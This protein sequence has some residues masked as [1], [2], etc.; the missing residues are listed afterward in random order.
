MITDLRAEAEAE[1]KIDN[2]AFDPYCKLYL[3]LYKLDGDSFADRSAYGHLCTNHGSLWTPRGRSFNGVDND[4]NCGNIEIANAITIGFW[5]KCSTNENRFILSKGID[6]TVQNQRYC[7]GL[8][9]YAKWFF[10]TTAGPKELVYPAT[11]YDGIWHLIMATYDSSTEVAKLYVVDRD[12][13]TSD[14]HTGTIT[15][16]GDIRLGRFYNY[17]LLLFLGS[18]GAFW[19]YS[20]ALTPQEISHHYIVGKE[21]FG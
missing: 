5:I 16:G 13:V 17:Q 9:T 1:A 7:F 6:L 4:I 18:L 14:T 8:G 21:L 11:F 3:P 2:F 10:R 20:R 12:K 19:L 15:T